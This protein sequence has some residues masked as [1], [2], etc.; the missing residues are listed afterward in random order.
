M[1]SAN[2]WVKATHCAGAKQNVYVAQSRIHALKLFTD[3]FYHTK[4]VWWTRTN[5]SF[6]I[7][8]VVCFRRWNRQEVKPSI[9]IPPQRNSSLFFPSCLSTIHGN[10][11]TKTESTLSLDCQ[12][13]TR[14]NKPM[15]IKINVSLYGLIC[16]Y[17]ALRRSEV[18]VIKATNALVPFINQLYAIKIQNKSKWR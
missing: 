14:G 6:F 17:L 16:L 2:K 15:C 4:H 3:I 9:M 13:H 12:C 7:N 5:K 1:S 18:K 8:S 11:L 10:V